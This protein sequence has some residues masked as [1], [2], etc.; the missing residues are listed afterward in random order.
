MATQIPAPPWTEDALGTERYEALAIEHK[1]C[2]PEPGFR[3]SLDLSAP[4][5]E[6]QAAAKGKPKAEKE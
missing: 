5:A 2:K 4:Y 6:Q 3:P 1:C